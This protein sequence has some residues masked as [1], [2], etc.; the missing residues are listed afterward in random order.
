MSD[1]DDLRAPPKLDEL[2][3]FALHAASR[4]LTKAYRPSLDGLGITYT[5]YV[6]LLAIGES[7]GAGIKDLGARLRLD[8]G[9]LTPLLKRLERDGLVT[10]ERDPADERRLVVRLT[11]EGRAVSSHAGDVTRALACTLDGDPAQIDELRERLT[12]LVAM[13]DE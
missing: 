4:A 10:R 8:S 12:A 11:D 7:D 6:T 2:L 5:Q 3:C 1:A 13:L 9:T